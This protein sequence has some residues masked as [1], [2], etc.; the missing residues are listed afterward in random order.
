MAK[1]TAATEEL[2]TQGTQALSAPD[3]GDLAAPAGQVA[4][5]FE[6][7]SNQDVSVPFIKLAHAMTPAVTEGKVEGL[8]PG[9][10]FDSVT[11]RT[12][13]N[14]KGLLFVAATTSHEYTEFKSLDEGG[15]FVGRHPIDSPLVAKAK[16]ESKKFGEYFVIREDGGRNELT[17][18]FYVFGIACDEDEAL[19]VGFGVIGFKSSMIKCYKTWMTQVR[20]HTITINGQKR[21]PPLFAHLNR[22]TTEVAKKDKFL[23]PVPIY[24]PGVNGR[25]SDSLLQPTDERFVAAMSLKDMM[26]RGIAKVDYAAQ[27]GQAEEVQPF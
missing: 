26:D 9:M 21:T 3:Y 11:G 12:W 8:A 7:Q 23:Y 24:T 17:E 15:G 4:Q 1:K 16:A 5:G 6:N 20:A 27:E 22:F 18:T 25:I 2:V 14:P 19:P 10:W 13:K